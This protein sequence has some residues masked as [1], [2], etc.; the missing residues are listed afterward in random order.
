MLTAQAT[1]THPWLRVALLAPLPLGCVLLYMRD[2]ANGGIFPPCPFRMLTGYECPGCGT[3]RALHQL[4]HGHVR[5]AFGLNPLSML[6]LPVLLYG[7]ASFVLS[8]VS[9]VRLPQLRIGER[10]AWLLP[11]VVVVKQRWIKATAV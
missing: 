3:G 5:E 4:M 10:A 11:A 7:L 8:S 9:D 6:M 2:P 1:R